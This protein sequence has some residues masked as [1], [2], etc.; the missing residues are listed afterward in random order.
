[1]KNIPRLSDYWHPAVRECAL[2]L[3]KDAPDERARLE[4][5]FLY[6][7]DGI[8][9]G[10]PLKGDLVRASETIRLGYGQCNT[11]SALFVA[12]CRTAGIP[13]QIHFSL[14][15][16][17]IQR[18]I[19]TG[20]AYRLM[21]EYISHS[22]VE[23]FIEDRWRSLDSFINDNC[24][25]LAGR[26]KL[27]EAGWEAGYS[28]ACSGGEANNDLAIDEERF[29]QMAAVT[30]DHGV[31]DDPADYYSSGL[32]RNRPGSFRLVLYAV[33]VGFLNRRVKKIRGACPSPVC[34]L[35]AIKQDVRA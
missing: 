27:K 22:W 29:I 19:F 24:F 32:Y 25:F 34:G 13:A 26:A 17:E 16:K 28:I 6:V 11:K 21:P 8:K 5:L 14:I 10:Y 20:I 1:M 31:W 9:F 23:V 12:L 18:G 3:T 33:M 2:R 15:R 7:R 35:Q 4:R 30:E